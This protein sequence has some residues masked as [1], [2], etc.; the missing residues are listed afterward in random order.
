MKNKTTGDVYFVVLF[1]L[2]FGDELEEALSASKGS[3]AGSQKGAMVPRTGDIESIPKANDI[4]KY[5][6]EYIHNDDDVD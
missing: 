1:A 2:L 3:V 5:R 6:E 4:S